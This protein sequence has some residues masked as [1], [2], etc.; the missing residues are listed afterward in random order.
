MVA[1][2]YT[3]LLI[4]VIDLTRRRR[5]GI[6]VYSHLIPDH[7]TAANPNPSHLEREQITYFF[8]TSG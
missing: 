3:N 2:G 7:S 5:D 6:C 4:L 1:N 8:L